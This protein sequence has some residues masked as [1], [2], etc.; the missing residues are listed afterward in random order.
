MLYLD[1]NLVYTTVM[2]LTAFIFFFSLGMSSLFT[3]RECIREYLDDKN[4]CSF[5]DAIDTAL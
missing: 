4:A 3:R 1:N 2:I 5:E